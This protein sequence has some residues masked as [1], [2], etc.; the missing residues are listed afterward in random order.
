MYMF[1]HSGQKHRR[2]A[3]GISSP[4]NDDLFLP[5]KERFHR[6][7]RIE[8]SLIFKIAMVPDVESSVLRTRSDNDGSRT[9]WHSAG[10]GELVDTI[11]LLDSHDLSGDGEMY[12]EF[13]GLQ[14][15]AAR[16]LC[17]RD[18]RWKT[19]VI[20]NLRT[21]A[22]LTTGSSSLNNDGR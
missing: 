6:C 3:S 11:G 20:F 5:T 2:L 1:S 12:T 18:P 9:Y 7:R 13:E 4:D 22:S 21:R 19:E 15:S 10:E 17:A 14:M 16:E 8:D